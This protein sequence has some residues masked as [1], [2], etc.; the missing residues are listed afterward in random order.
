MIPVGNGDQ[1]KEWIFREDEMKQ[2]AIGID[3]GS[4]SG[5]AL[6]VDVRSGREIAEEVMDYPHAVMSE[7]LPDGTVLPPLFALQHPQDYLDVLH[8]TVPALLKKT[9]V[10]NADIVG[11][12]VD[13]TA[14]TVLP[15]DREGVP[16][17]FR[18]EYAGR[19][20]AYVKLWK[21]HAA[22]PQADRINRIAAERKEIFPKRY[23]GTISSEWQLP[24]L[25][26][27]FENDPQILEEADAFCEAGDWIVRMLTGAVVRNSCA[28]GYKGCYHK[29]EGDVSEAFYEALAPGF[30]RARSLLK[31][32]VVASGSRAGVVTEQG[33][34]R[35]GLLPGTPVAAATIDAHAAVPAVGICAPAKMLM[36]MGTSTCHMMLDKREIAAPGI[37]GVVEDGILPGFFG[38]EAGQ[39]CVGDH[40]QWVVDNIVP[41]RVAE[42]AK[43][44][45]ISLHAY[46]T[47]L[48]KSRSWTEESLL[49]LDWF[50]GVRT[51]LVNARLKGVVTGFTLGTRVEDIYRAL[52]EAT[53]FGTR[54]IVETMEQSD[55]PV[56]ELYACG[57]IAAKNPF[58]M[59]IYAD[60]CGK[61]IRVARSKQAVALGAAIFGAL[62][63][64]RENGGYDTVEEA[65]SAMACPVAACYKPEPVSQS[66]EEIRYRKYDALFDCFKSGV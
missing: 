50:N 18:H 44:R 32:K 16:L 17:C 5:R 33:A 66:L 22:Q 13:F 26:E 45:G 3:F 35:S 36:I 55:I 63:G 30:G 54:K 41:A 12:G 37:S 62:A 31:G 20:H 49:A 1:E 42:E 52:M 19:P 48:A 29:A 57:G 38:Y 4:L 34:E 39:A 21:H 14:C 10:S 60:V 25:L 15:V 61:T 59:Q 23:G 7:C 8:A 43:K 56:S 28:A 47:E 9:G 65:V 27:I 51:P 11:V 2:Y 64:G 58:L 40:F 24:K 6:L 46:L 53:A